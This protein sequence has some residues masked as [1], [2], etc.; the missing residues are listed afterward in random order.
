MTD[1]R[2]GCDAAQVISD[3]LGEMGETAIKTTV[4]DA[5]KVQEPGHFAFYRLSALEMVQQKT[6][7]PWQLHLAR[8]L[9][10]RT[11]GLVGAKTREERTGFGG[12]IVNLGLDGEIRAGKISDE[13]RVPGDEDP[14]LLTPAGILYGEREVFWA[15]SGGCHGPDLYVSELDHI[16]VL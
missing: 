12:V 15:V 3:G 4:V 16:A 6:L 14:G 11:F 9:R 10:S 8:F 2:G 13:E 1:N 7:T 5:I